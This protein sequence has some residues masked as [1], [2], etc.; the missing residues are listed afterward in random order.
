M[1]FN[2][3]NKKENTNLIIFFNG[4]GM[5]DSV[6]RHLN[7]E[8][9]D[10][11]TICDYNELSPLPDISEYKEI[12]VI[13]WSM[14]VM[15]AT[16]YNCSQKSATAINGT[17]FPINAEYGINPRIYK[18]MEMNFNELSAKKFI[19]NMFDEIPGNFVFPK[20]SINNQKSELSAL[21]KYKSNENYHY[22]RII[23]SNNDK[24][25]PS[26]SQINYWKTPEI[27]NSGHCPFFEYTKWEELL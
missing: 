2:W 14:G 24:I 23:V 11:L 10:V 19:T 26:K 15:I 5:D 27:I 7:P 4:W 21:R 13:A 12:H 1:N 8:N 25:I 16:L 22:T 20:R 6:V 18:L 9:Y 17:L 3:L